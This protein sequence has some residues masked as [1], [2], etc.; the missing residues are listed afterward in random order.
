MFVEAVDKAL[1]LAL[2]DFEEGET[3]ASIELDGVVS[4]RNKLIPDLLSF[5]QGHNLEIVHF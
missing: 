1:F 4:F 2:D 3:L 5:L